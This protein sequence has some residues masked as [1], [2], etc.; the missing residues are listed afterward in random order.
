MFRLYLAWRLLR[1][2]RAL[3]GVLTY[4]GSLVEV[5]RPEEG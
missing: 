3:L 1:L 4:C 2:I 5:L